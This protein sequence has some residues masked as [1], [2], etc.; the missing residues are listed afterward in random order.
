MQEK[1]PLQPPTC[2]L[3]VAFGDL[4]LQELCHFLV[5]F[6]FPVTT[7]LVP[8]QEW[9]SKASRSTWQSLI[10]VRG[11]TALSSVQGLSCT[12]LPEP[13]KLHIVHQEVPRFHQLMYLL[14]QLLFLLLLFVGLLVLCSTGKSR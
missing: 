13:L 7:R 1:K 6:P 8:I 5:F 14:Y 11:Q 10:Q 12:Q 9:S 2:F 4:T 3:E